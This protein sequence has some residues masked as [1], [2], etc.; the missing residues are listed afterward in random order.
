MQIKTTMSYHLTIVSMP[1]LKKKHKMKKTT[2][3]YKC[4]CGCREIDIF[5]DMVSGH[6]E[7]GQLPWKMISRFFKALKME[8]SQDLAVFFPNIYLEEFK[9]FGGGDVGS[10]MVV[11]GSWFCALGVTT[12]SVYLGLTL[13]FLPPRMATGKA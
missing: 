3:I 8:F 1:V 7:M 12:G 6:C 9:S 5:L 11:G 4:W 2:R 10:Y 13:A